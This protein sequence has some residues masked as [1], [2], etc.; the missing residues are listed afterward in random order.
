[1]QE[2]YDVAEQVFL[3]I[4]EDLDN[5]T[6]PEDIPTETETSAAETKEAS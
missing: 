6:E 3:R 5:T 4:M 2:T 1:M